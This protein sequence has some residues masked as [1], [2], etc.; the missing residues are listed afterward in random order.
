MARGQRGANLLLSTAASQSHGASQ[1]DCI[2]SSLFRE[3]RLFGLASFSSSSHDVAASGRVS[4]LG[5]G[6]STVIG[7]VVF[8]HRG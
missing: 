4:A 7:C 1:A 3:R 5:A 2:T 8:I 6:V